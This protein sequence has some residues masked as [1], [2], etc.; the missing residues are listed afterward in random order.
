MRQRFSGLEIKERLCDGRCTLVLGGELDM[1]SAAMLHAAVARVCNPGTTGGR[2]TLDLRKL[3]FIDSTGL[4]EIILTNRLCDRDGL[5]FA[6]IRGPQ[7][8][9]RL[10]EITGLVDALPFDEDD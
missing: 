3:V 4:A 2:I 5:D 10:F 6:L 1:A 7:A 8:V 9:H